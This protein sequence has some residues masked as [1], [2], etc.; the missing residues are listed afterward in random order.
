M[1]TTIDPAG[2]ARNPVVAGATAHRQRTR[3]ALPPGIEHRP[4]LTASRRT[5]D[6]SLRGEWH[7]VSE[8]DEIAV[9]SI[10]VPFERS[11]H[12]KLRIRQN[13]LDARES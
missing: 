7:F 1:R 2:G 4:L 8:P 11:R 10:N 9:E 6:G 12:G 13:V 5:N 3:A